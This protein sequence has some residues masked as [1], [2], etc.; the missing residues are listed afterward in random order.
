MVTFGGKA[1]TSQNIENST[2]V[3]FFDDYPLK[4][5]RHVFVQFLIYS[6]LGKD[7]ALMKW[8]LE[9]V[10]LGKLYLYEFLKFI[11]KI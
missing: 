4:L 2:N 6:R 8:L 1:L 10:I 5:N 9:K 3:D 11:S 7:L